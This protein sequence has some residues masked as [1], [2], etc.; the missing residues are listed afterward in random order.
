LRRQQQ[1]PRP[2]S[3]RDRPRAPAADPV[4]YSPSGIRSPRSGP[5]RMGFSE[6]LIERSHVVPVHSER[7]WVEKPHHRHRRRTPPADHFHHGLPGGEHASASTGGGSNLLPVETLRRVDI[8]QVPL[9]GRRGR[10]RRKLRSTSLGVAW[11]AAS[12]G[13]ATR[14]QAP[15][16]RGQPVGG[17]QGFFDVERRLEAKAAK[18]A[19]GM[20]SGRLLR[21]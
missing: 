11:A 19:R 2:A 12:S 1:S 21:G 3:R 15:R 18:A 16:R 8:D 5:R 20:P 17:T 9:C 10:R 7:P 6:A 4:D 14:P 13:S